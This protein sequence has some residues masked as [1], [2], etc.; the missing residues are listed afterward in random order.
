M[1]FGIGSLGE[2]QPVS[3]G[4]FLVLFCENLNNLAVHD[5]LVEGNDLAIS[6]GAGCG[7]ANLAV[8]SICEVD[9][10]RILGELDDIAFRREGKNVILEEI[11]LE[12]LEKFFIVPAD[13]FLPFLEL[14]HPLESVRFFGDDIFLPTEETLPAAL[15]AFGVDPVSGDAELSLG[16]H[17]LSPDLDLENPALR[18]EDGRME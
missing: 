1:G 8:D 12:S 11:D 14:P 7:I 3:A 6:L 17:F 4:F 15:V 2:V 18:P 5:M 13:L 9:R 10:R 16:M